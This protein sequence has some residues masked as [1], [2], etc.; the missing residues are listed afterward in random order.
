MGCPRSPSREEAGPKGA[1]RLVKY[2]WTP[3]PASG[4]LVTLFSTFTVWL[5][6]KQAQ[7]RHILPAFSSVYI[8]ISE[9]SQS[10]GPLPRSYQTQRGYQGCPAKFAFKAKGSIIFHS[11]EAWL[12]KGFNRPA[13]TC[14]VCARACACIHARVHMGS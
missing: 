8:Q 11:V 7:G 5:H 4:G 2:A 13:P 12:N 6:L 10:P 3:T 14:P 1:L 9:F